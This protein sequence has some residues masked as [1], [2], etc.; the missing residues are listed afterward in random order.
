[1]TS[2]VPMTGRGLLVGPEPDE[3]K[4][5]KLIVQTIF[6]ILILRRNWKECV[7]QMDPGQ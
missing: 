4:L 3:I 5:P 6:R 7:T 1:M 2:G